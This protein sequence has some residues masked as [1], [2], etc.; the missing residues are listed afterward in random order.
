ML[1]GA[2]GLVLFFGIFPPVVFTGRLRPDGPVCPKEKTG[3]ELFVLYRYGLLFWGFPLPEQPHGNNGS[4][5]GKDKCRDPDRSRYQGNCPGERGK[6]FI[7][8]HR[9]LLPPAMVPRERPGDFLRA[10]KARIV[11]WRG[12]RLS[13]RVRASGAVYL[14]AFLVLDIFI[15]S[16]FRDGFV[17]L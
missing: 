15:L 9:A 13:R 8:D 16:R 12:Q 1:P 2:T 7:H 3:Q 4:E 6:V 10:G 11:S 14:V 5:H 17:L